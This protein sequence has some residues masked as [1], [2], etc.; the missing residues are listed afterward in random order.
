MSAQRYS[1]PAIIL[2]W[3]MAAGVFFM[4]G[5]GI[6]MEYVDMPRA[7][8]FQL[9]Q[10]HKST[11][12]LVLVALALRILVRLWKHP[13]ALPA[14]FVRWEKI[15]ADMGHGGLYMALALMTLSGWLMVSSSSYGLPTMVFSAFEWP[16]MPMVAGN[17]LLNGLARS[18]HFWAA[19][20]LG[21]LLAAHLGAVVKHAA[22]DRENLLRRIWW[23]RT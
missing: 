10:L 21:A 9:V 15:A 18:T 19:I 20:A 13:P 22:L 3:V 8:K 11:G 1:S 2:H 16:H 17:E 12:V 5:T 14:A 23:G 6:C 7:D 4:L